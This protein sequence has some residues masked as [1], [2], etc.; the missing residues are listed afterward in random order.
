MSG[1]RLDWQTDGSDWPN[2]EASR[3]VDAGGL[4][5]HVQIAGAGPC[6]LLLHGS[7]A[8]T[9]SWRDLL[10]GLA[11]HWRVI[12][13]DLPGHAFSGTPAADRLGL[14]GVAAALAALLRTL[15]VEPHAA[16]GHSAGAAIALHMQLAGLLKLRS[17]VSLNGA[18]LPLP[19]LAGLLFPPAAKA[20]AVLPLTAELFARSARRP[21]AVER[22]IAGTGS[23]IDARGMAL[24]ARLVRCPAH[25]RGV[26][27]MMARWDV[28]P[29]ARDMHRLDAALTLVAARDDRTVPADMAQRVARRV[30][31]ARCL[32]LD[33][34]GHLS[35]EQDAAA[36][37]D[38]ILAAASAQR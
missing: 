10:P 3:F 37:A 29:L 6:L 5:W 25:V 9:H 4:R 16:V 38:L 35:H 34:G 28:V 8:A 7:G 24:Y 27:G 30:P 18:L 36:H 11:A 1:G 13:P 31:G 2:R 26:L 32:L 14:P 33:Q 22:L 15:D 20:L 23:R 21:G 17:L 12:A 19:G